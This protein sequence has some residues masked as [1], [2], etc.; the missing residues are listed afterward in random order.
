[1]MHRLVGDEQPEQDDREQ[2]LR[3]AEA[4]RAEGIAVHRAPER[5]DD[6]CRDRHHEAVDEP[7]AIPPEFRSGGVRAAL[8]GRAGPRSRTA[9]SRCSLELISVPVL[10]LPTSTTY[11][12]QQV[13]HREPDEHRV[14]TDADAQRRPSPGPTGGCRCRRWRRRPWSPRR[15]SGARRGRTGRPRPRRPC[16]MSVATAAPRATGG[17]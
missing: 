14:Q 2:Q 13:Q 11:T 7:G 16:S 6:H 3:A 8:P 12:G 10:R 15:F 17:P 1:M 9:G 5:R 4:P